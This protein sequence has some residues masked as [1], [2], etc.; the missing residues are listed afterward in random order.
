[1]NVHP[2]QS[3]SIRRWFVLLATPLLWTAHFLLV[4]AVASL[5]ITIRGIA[6]RPTQVVSTLLTV[7]ILAAIVAFGWATHSGRIPAWGGPR[8]DL[9]ALWRRCGTFLA[10]LSF[11]GVLWQGLPAILVPGAPAA[12]HALDGGANVPPLPVP[13]RD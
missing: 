11:C 3:A 4:Y 6:G 12:H 9:A 5:E 2:S 10:V 7:V 13:G 1:M 8:E